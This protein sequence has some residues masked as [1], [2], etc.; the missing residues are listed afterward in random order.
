MPLP[1][2]TTFCSH[3]EGKSGTFV[4]HTLHL[5]DNSLFVTKGPV[6]TR[7]QFHSMTKTSTW[8]YKIIFTNSSKHYSP[9]CFTPTRITKGAP[10]RQLVSPVPWASSPKLTGKPPACLQVATGVRSEN[11]NF[12]LS[13]AWEKDIFTF[14][15]SSR[16]KQKPQRWLFPAAFLTFM[17]VTERRPF[18]LGC[19]VAFCTFN[20]YL[21]LCCILL[22]SLYTGET[23]TREK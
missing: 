12:Y 15:V 5:R 4:G 19:V 22:I 13:P 3:L 14:F 18:W 2:G 10:E 7:C 16:S 11:N 21:S 23:L 20:F 8:F 1:P 17:S 6:F 9:Y